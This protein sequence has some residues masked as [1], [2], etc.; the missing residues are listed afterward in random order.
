M[1]MNKQYHQAQPVTV[2]RTIAST[3]ALIASGRSFH[4]STMNRRSAE[5]ADGATSRAGNGWVVIWGVTGGR[6]ASL[7]FA[8]VRDDGT[9]CPEMSGDSD[10]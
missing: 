6:S 3:P 4:A 1:A 9:E 10:R 5:S 2:A 7:R 8:S